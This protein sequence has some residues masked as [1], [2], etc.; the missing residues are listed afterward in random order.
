MGDAVQALIATAKAVAHY[1]KI[2]RLRDAVEQV[3]DLEY[4]ISKAEDALAAPDAGYRAGWLAGRDAA[5]DA[6][7]AATD[8]AI[9]SRALTP[10]APW[11]PPPEGERV[12]ADVLS[13]RQRQRS[14]EGWSNEHDDNLTC[15]E[16]AMAAVAYV[17]SSRNYPR[18]KANG[19]SWT[20]S[21]WPWDLK[22]WKPTDRRR[23]LV[24]AAALTL[25][26]IERLDR[27]TAFAPLP[28]EG[29]A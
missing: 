10:P 11:A 29:E 3:A 19:K 15:G 6:Y 8:A 21:R 22:R 2:G 28:P 5:A 26:E 17:E 24:K 18:I 20:P 4:A 13:E 16:L 14:E 23:D 12:M 1:A 25:A 7:D 9:A 27:A